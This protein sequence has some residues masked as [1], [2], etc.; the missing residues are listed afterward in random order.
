MWGFEMDLNG[1]MHRLIPPRSLAEK[2][3]V[4]FRDQVLMIM[5]P[6]LGRFAPAAHGIARK[7]C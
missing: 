1:F 3:V 4:V 7:V 5:V 2:V 6:D